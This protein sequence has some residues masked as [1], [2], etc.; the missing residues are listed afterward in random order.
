MANYNTTCFRVQ[1]RASN[2]KSAGPI[3]NLDVNLHLQFKLYIGQHSLQPVD[4]RTKCFHITEYN[5]LIHYLNSW[6]ILLLL[7]RWKQD[8]KFYHI[9]H[10]C[11]SSNAAAS[12][13]TKQVRVRRLL[14]ERV[15]NISSWAECNFIV[16]FYAAGHPGGICISILWK[17]LIQ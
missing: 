4:K 13:T 8:V 5:I 9:Q 11:C 16:D 15:Y 1:K 7:C 12:P 3:R 14:S 6:V 2:Y 17:C 10:Y